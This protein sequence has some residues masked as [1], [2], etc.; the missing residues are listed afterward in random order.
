[1]RI[2][3]HGCTKRSSGERVDT[4]RGMSALE[5]RGL[6]KLCSNR[7]VKDQ[8]SRDLFWGLVI[9]D[10]CNTICQKR[11]FDLA[12]YSAYYCREE[13]GDVLTM[14][15]DLSINSLALAGSFA[16]P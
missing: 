1:M 12:T 10:F 11:T 7:E 5:H 2:C 8:L 9:F 4:L 14:A 3:D 16:T 6:K 15:R 13:S